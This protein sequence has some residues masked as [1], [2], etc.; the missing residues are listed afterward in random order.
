MSGATTIPPHAAPLEA[1]GGAPAAPLRSR[2]ISGSVWTIL[3]FMAGNVLRLGGNLILVRLVPQHAFGL[4]GL[5]SALLTGLEMLSDLGG[6]GSIVQNQRGES[7][8]FRRTAWTLATIRGLVL[9]AIACALAYPFA[10]GYGHPV[11]AW[12]I[13]IC[14]LSAVTAGLGSTKLH[15]L[16]RRMVLAPVVLIELAGHAFGLVVMIAWALVDASV[17]A[18]VFG[19]V[20]GAVLKLVLSHA[21]VPGTPDRF[22]WDRASASAIVHFGRWIFVS[23]LVTF[24]VGQSDRL[25]FGAM[26]PLELLAAYSVASMLA[27]MPA[28]AVSTL[29]IR[30]MFPA[31]SSVGRGGENLASHFTRARR[32]ILVG[33]GW[34]LAGMIGGGPTM[35]ALLYPAGFAPAGWILSTLAAGSWLSVMEAGN[36]TALLAQGRGHL[37][38]AAS[39]AKLVGMIA[40]IPLGYAAGGFPGAVGGY[41]AAEGVRYTVSTLVARRHGLKNLRQDAA[42]TALVA[43][44]S[45][46]GWLAARAAG[47]WPVAAQAAA[48]FVA[49]TAVWLPVG[50]GPARQLLRRRRA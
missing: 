4:M 43:V 15:V 17:W 13:P 37:M 8:E 40:L 10:A 19:G 34:V 46:A 2:V 21:A 9:W 41:A 6:G 1:G 47:S 30:V 44:A 12:I 39:T 25:V 32:P 36:G 3:G 26:I 14:G 49:V 45:A 5:V 35:I 23:S 27:I 11:L 16:S 33:S 20:A 22:G 50:I 48:V 38:A 29:T 31:L 24:L 7:A 18:L 28:S 42:H